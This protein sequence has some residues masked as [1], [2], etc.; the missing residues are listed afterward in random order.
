MA[1][2]GGSDINT[3]ACH[4][5]EESDHG[6]EFLPTEPGGHDFDYGNQH[7]GRSRADQDAADNGGG[8]IDG[9]GKTDSADAGQ[10]EEE[11]QG[12]ARAERPGDWTDHELKRGIGKEIRR[13]QQAE[14]GPFQV[15]VTHQVKGEHGR[16]LTVEVHEE[17]DA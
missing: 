9:K 1:E 6:G 5:Y 10:P 7:H 12:L 4:G 11:T 16:S 8:Q 2:W 14:G 15:K 3:D 13:P 17:V